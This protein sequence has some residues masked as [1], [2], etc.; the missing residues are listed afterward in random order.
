MKKNYF[1][2]LLLLYVFGANAQQQQVNT[3]HSGLQQ[4]SKPKISQKADLAGLNLN[5]KLS[6]FKKKSLV[7]D[8]FISKA[9]G[10]T[11]TLTYSDLKQQMDDPNNYYINIIDNIN[12]TNPV[13]AQVYKTGSTPLQISKLGIFLGK[14]QADLNN[15]VSVK[16][17]IYNLTAGGAP[18]TEIG[19]VNYLIPDVNLSLRYVSFPSPIT[20]TGGFAV[21]ISIITA[22][23]EIQTM[24][25]DE[26]VNTTYDEELLYLKFGTNSFATLKSLFAGIGYD[27]DFDLIM[28]PI[29]S[30]NVDTPSLTA[31]PTAGCTNSPVNLVG[32]YTPTDLASNRFLNLYEFFEYFNY[33]GITNESL[34]IYPLG[35]ANP[36][37]VYPSASTSYT[38]TTPGNYTP[39]FEYAI[40]R[41]SIPTTIDCYSNVSTNITINNPPNATFSYSG[42]SFC[43]SS[44]NETPTA[45]TPGGTY[46]AT[47]AGLSINTS[48]GVINFSTSTIGNY[49]VT[50][51]VTSGACQASSTQNVAVTAAPNAT[52]SYANSSYC[53]NGTNPQVI[54]GTGAS[55]GTFTASPSGLSINTST[56]EINLSTSTAGS[57]TVTNTI[58]AAGGCAADV[59]TF[60][61]SVT[62]APVASINP[63]AAVCQDAGAVTL[64]ATPAGGTF[65][66]TGV[67]GNSFDPSALSA[68]TYTITYSVTQSGCTASD[69]KSVTVTAPLNATFSY[70][71]TSYC[72]NGT[73]PQV[74][75]SS[76]ASA[77]T[78]S[79]SPSGLSINSVTGTINLAAST[80]GSYTV[81]NT[82]AATG[83]CSGD[84]KTFNVSIVAVPTV[85]I[86]P[87]SSAVCQDAAVI[88][89]SATPAGGT[90]SGNAGVS[91]NSFDPSV[92]SA[93][94]YTITYSVTQSGCTA[95]DSKSVNVT[96]PL[97]ATFSYV[98]TSYCSNGTDPQVVLSSGASAGTFS[99][100]PSGLSLNPVTGTINL[101]ASTAGSYT[102]T[103]TVAA[104]GGCAADV[105]TF[106]VDVVAVPTVTIDPISAAICQDAG[107]VTLSAT[108]AGGTFSGNAGVSGNS[109]DPSVLSAGTYTITYSVTQSGCTASDSK[110]VTVSTPLKATFSY[111]N[112]SYCLDDPNPQVVLGTGASAGAFTASPSGL[113]INASTGAINLSAST[114]GNY[115]VTNTV[116]AAGGCPG[117]VKTATITVDECLSVNEIESIKVQLFPVPAGNELNISV[118]EDVTAAILTI[119]GKLALAPF[120]I[121]KQSTYTLDTRPL[122]KGVYLLKLTTNT[123]ELV[124][125]IILE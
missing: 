107:A 89:L 7:S 95:S 125:R 21:G 27:Y 108:P 6:S 17:S 93:G 112:N 79:A 15:A 31:T 97:D 117:D 76:G 26:A 14:D 56:G 86:D 83:G 73:D 91:G 100:S 111:A 78:F 55:A 20:V 49:V 36:S 84:V 105:K 1:V 98:N 8:E 119:E 94:T 3:I 5:N 110:S 41:F 64:S 85:A 28:Y 65:S 63:I 82:V 19:S 16:L 42:N 106:N 40:W 43:Q 122:A 104:A 22:G 50:Y 48:T 70:A 47:P 120:N 96:A 114:A 39:V 115:T 24:I 90:F 38:Y 9:M 74:V 32:T 124:R 123:S 81:T 2:L 61:V 4:L 30:Y 71:N 45:T 72:S 34:S 18:N 88:T 11:D 46:S 69:S 66:G 92:L 118:S 23:K 109:F 59:K 102:V 60:N 75:L 35:A 116:A 29:V 44:S 52:F 103:N 54:L 99:A 33:S 37:I 62:A 101:A 51:N 13:Y 10:C 87:I 113:S 53:S 67:S 25:N 58:A 80:A 57:Y 121:S 68:G 12:L 77:G